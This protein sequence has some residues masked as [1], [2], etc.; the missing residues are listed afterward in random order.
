M[1]SCIY[2]WAVFVQLLVAVVSVIVPHVY[3]PAYFGIAFVM[4]GTFLLLFPHPCGDFLLFPPVYSRVMTNVQRKNK[5]QYTYT[6]IRYRGGW[7]F[8]QRKQNKVAVIRLSSTTFR[9]IEAS[10]VRACCFVLSL[11]RLL[12]RRNSPRGKC[13]AI[14]KRDRILRYGPA[15]KRKYTKITREVR[16]YAPA[17][18]HAAPPLISPGAMAI[19]GGLI[20]GFDMWCAAYYFNHCIFNAAPAG[21]FLCISTATAIARALQ[22]IIPR[23]AKCLA[24]VWI[25][26]MQDI[27]E[28]YMRA[29]N[30]V[31]L[32]AKLGRR[33]GVELRMRAAPLSG[34]GLIATFLEC[35]ISSS[36]YHAH[37]G[38]T[39]INRRKVALF[40]LF[41]LSGVNL[42][43]RPPKDGTGERGGLQAAPFW[44]AGNP[45]ARTVGTGTEGSRPDDE[46]ED[47]LV[48]R[49]ARIANKP[50]VDYARFYRSTSLV[51]PEYNSQTTERGGAGRLVSAVYDTQHSSDSPIAKDT[52]PDS[53]HRKNPE[54]STPS[55]PQFKM[56]EGSPSISEEYDALGADG[57][58]D[59]ESL[60]YSAPQSDIVDESLNIVQQLRQ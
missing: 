38:K 56:N 26:N 27:D 11:A 33:V 43:G 49:S 5:K 47:R 45:P 46:N 8:L 39:S 41:L 2:K 28:K 6:Q 9:S 16:L 13:R 35:A 60:E 55:I 24:A 40:V 29:W 30:L 1:H 4:C 42:K 34:I 18:L 22:I 14:E 48:R 52:P 53:P 12:I 50:P 57:E 21:L 23:I 3:K 10:L 37:Y 31:K 25:L 58:G 54:P 51:N 20:L 59:V 19:R 15:K 36:F 32:L 17:S 7:R 44:A